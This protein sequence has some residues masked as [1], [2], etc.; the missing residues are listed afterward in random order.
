M[1]KTEQGLTYW[2]DIVEKQIASGT[3]VRLEDIR[4]AFSHITEKQDKGLYGL[5]NYHMA[6]YD[7]QNGKIDECLD[8][9]NESIR[10]MVGTPQERN[11]SRCYNILGVIAHGQNNLLM[12]AEQY[13]K[14]L[15]YA[16]RYQDHLLRNTIISNMADMYYRMGVYDKAYECFRESMSEYKA[17]GDKSATGMM[18][19]MMLLASYGYCL[20]M[21]DRIEEAKSVAEQLFPLKEGAY[22]EYF[23]SLY[24][25]TF[26][27]LQNY[28][29]GR[30]EIA[31][32]F[33]ALAVQAAVSK[34]QLAGDFDGVL[35]LLELL[36][37]LGRYDYLM[38]VLDFA[39]L[40]AQEEQ[41]EG[42]MM[43]LLVYRL[44]YCGDKLTE[45]R[46]MQSAKLFFQ[47]QEEYG[48]SESSLVIHMME[49]R[50]RLWRIEE[51]QRELEQENTRLL[52][53]ADH[54][55]LSRLY[56]KRRLNRCLEEY[57]EK[58]MA[59]SLAMSILFVDID[60]FKQLNDCYGH[61]KG[62]ECIRAVADCIGRSM[63]D[64]FVARYGGDEFMVVACGRTEE[65]VSQGAERIVDSVRALQ[66]PNRNAG[67][68][69]VLT[70]TVGVIHAVPRK[71]NKV[72]DFLAAADEA[73]YLQKQEMRGCARFGKRPE[74]D[75]G[76]L[77]LAE[78]AEVR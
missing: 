14:A 50:R 59:E 57:F 29:L 38:Q 69:A 7:L 73:L 22:G 39:E 67:D 42:L 54:D 31:N 10:C 46:Y 27:S 72:W 1:G 77:Q 24:A 76:S 5:C 58:A 30:K 15:G 61:Q 51:G 33:L 44:K 71:P 66:I 20:C 60:Y 70:V 68:G 8:C 16:A 35:N 53:Q 36:V 65:H 37:L 25:N 55:E 75:M 64:D 63:P 26:F 28:K 47:I 40:L 12:A 13:N 9:L 6:F 21:A 48:N 41:N 45:E 32:H 74:S 34:K 49:I 19:Y 62:D 23:P 17:S 2:T 11:V 4:N 52:Y 78:A 18:N 43:Q 3:S 56:N